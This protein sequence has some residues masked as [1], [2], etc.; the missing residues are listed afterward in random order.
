MN[1]SESLV[2]V[3]LPLP[4]AKIYTRLLEVRRST[5]RALAEHLGMTRPSVYDNLKILIQDGLVSEMRED[6]KK[7]FCIDS[8]HDL[9]HFLDGRVATLVAEKEMLDALLPKYVGGDSV[10]PSIKSFSGID[11]IKRA[12]GEMLWYRN[13]ETCTVWPTNDMAEVLGDEFLTDLNRKRIARGISVRSIWPSSER[14]SVERYPF[15]G[16]GKEHLRERRIAPQGMRW[17]MSY[18][19]YADRVMFISS[20][21]ESF[22]FVVQSNDHASLIRVNFEAF[23]QVSTP[24]S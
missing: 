17:S 2:K 4:A 13:I 24:T 9:T 11:G 18:W 6:G 19:L 21:K 15:L 3:G 23:W 5:A 8:P 16:V 22:G 1:L 14:G 7:V 20:H 12:L 10:A